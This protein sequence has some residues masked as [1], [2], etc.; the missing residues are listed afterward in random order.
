[1]ENT[2]NKTYK[3]KNNKIKS[4][5][6]TYDNNFFNKINSFSNIPNKKD[7]LINSNDRPIRSSGKYN[8][9]FIDWNNEWERVNEVILK[10][11]NGEEIEDKNEEKR[12]TNYINKEK[13]KNGISMDSFE[14]VFK[15][16]IKKECYICLKNFDLK[17]KVR[18]L[19]C[20][21]MF[22]ESCLLPWIKYNSKCPVCKFDFKI[23]NKGEKNEEN[24]YDS[25]IN[26]NYI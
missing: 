21:H 19:L 25:E 17:N 3:S 7:K 15:P 16:D 11:E 5:N 9:N 12:I 22:C 24:E 18:R 23:I 6:K 1:M 14:I 8:L 2:Y 26:Q 4:N 20:K 13:E 10:L